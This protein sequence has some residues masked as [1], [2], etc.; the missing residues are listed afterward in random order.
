MYSQCSAYSQ[1]CDPKLQVRVVGDCGFGEAKDRRTLEQ[2]GC[3]PTNH[4][5][6]MLPDRSNFGPIYWCVLQRI[7]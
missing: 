3:E 6:L 4:G 2:L 7:C 5:Y 1:A